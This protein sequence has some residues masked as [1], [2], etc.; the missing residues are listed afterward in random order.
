MHDYTSLQDPAIAKH[1]LEGGVGV[2]PTDTVYGVVAQATRPEA[3][4]RVYAVK[5][6]DNKPGTVIAADIDQLVDLGIK[7]RY[8]VPVAQYW[9]GAIS[10]IIPCGPELGHLH[11][12]LNSLAMRIPD[13][14]ALLELL[15]TTGPLLTSSANLTGQ[16]TSVNVQQAKDYFGDTV[17][18]Y[19]DG[20]DLSGR[21]PSTLVRVLDDELEVLRQG[22]VVIK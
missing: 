5:V 16:P 19:V 10:V 9:P 2:V 20:G 6:R 21:L 4:A 12:G 3:A 22:S 14:P 15:R 7:R 1:L 8:L 13:D 18:F 11:L 17:D